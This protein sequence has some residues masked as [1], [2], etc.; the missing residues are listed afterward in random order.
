[1][2]VKTIQVR[3]KVDKR[4]IVSVTKALK[5]LEKVVVQLKKNGINIE[6]NLFKQDKNGKKG[7]M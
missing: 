6:M 3:Y 5:D 4:D 7:R 2:A 1:M